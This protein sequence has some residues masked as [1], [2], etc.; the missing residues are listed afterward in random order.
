MTVPFS[1]PIDTATGAIPTA[2]VVL[3]RRLSDLAH[4]FAETPDGDDVVYRVYN[5]DVPAAASDIPF[6]T[7]VLLPGK[8]GDEYFMT[9]GHFHEVR[10]RAEIYIG[11][12]GEGLL[13][14]ATEDGRHA[15]EPIRPGV[16]NYVPGGWAHRSVN[17]GPEPLV[18]F[19]AYVGD[20]GHD[21]Q[22][23]DANGF[24]VRVVEREGEPAIVENAAFR[25][26]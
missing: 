24:P 23:I 7:T 22:T 4:A 5:V 12:S 3:E 9:K 13:L 1:R 8:V 6:G 14:M 15:V 21:Y 16:V 18:F 19:A 26:S 20:A 10:S 2:D 11:F 17:T 25:P